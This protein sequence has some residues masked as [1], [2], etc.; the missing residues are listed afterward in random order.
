M[1]MACIF[2]LFSQI[3]EQGREYGRKKIVLFSIPKIRAMDFM[4]GKSL[5]R[6]SAAETLKDEHMLN[7]HVRPF[8]WEQGITNTQS[9]SGD[10]GNAYLQIR[11]NCIQFYDKTIL[12][13]EDKKLLHSFTQLKQ[14]IPVD[15]L[16]ISKSLNINIH[17]VKKN[18]DPQQ[19]IFDSSNSFSKIKNWKKEC[20]SMNQNYYSVLDKGAFDISL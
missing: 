15:I 20:E 7:F 9:V 1:L 14:P 12:I 5:V 11:L 19:I 2:L 8:E 17:E 13:L 6:Y 16:V 10:F 3:L 4:N 18:F